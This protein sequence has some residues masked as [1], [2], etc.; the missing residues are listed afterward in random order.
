LGHFVTDELAD[1]L[2]RHYIYAQEGLD[3]QAFMAELAVDEALEAT[4]YDRKWAQRIAGFALL[5]FFALLIIHGI[6][7]EVPLFLASFAG[8]AAALPGIFKLRRMRGLAF[9]EA[10]LE[11]A[12]YYFL[13]PLFLSIT[14]LTSA[15]FFVV[16]QT[17]VVRGIDVLG[18]LH[19]AFAQF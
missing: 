3:E 4:A 1:G 7:N 6:V 14:L 11:Y 10:Q 17:L 15:G 18:H 13:F 19:V 9:R 5:P 16:L 8:F 12:E 2:D